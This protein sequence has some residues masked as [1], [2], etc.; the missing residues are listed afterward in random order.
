MKRD[1]N[2]F[3]GEEEF[4]KFLKN[5]IIQY[6][7]L[8]FQNKKG[9][10]SFI[11]NKL[12]DIK[13]PKTANY[14]KITDILKEKSKDFYTDM[15]KVHSPL[16]IAH[17]YS[18]YRMLIDIFWETTWIKTFSP[19]YKFLF[20]EE[21]EIK[22][23]SDQR[24]YA[25]KIITELSQQELQKKWIEY[26]S[27]PFPFLFG[28]TT[29]PVI[30]Y[31]HLT[32]GPLGFL[33]SLHYRE[34]EIFGSY[35]PV[36]S[37][38]VNTTPTGEDI[39]DWEETDAFKV[40]S[41]IL[42]EL[43]RKINEVTSSYPLYANYLKSI[44]FEFPYSEWEKQLLNF[45]KL[46]K[47]QI[48]EDR[49]P[50]MFYQMVQLTAMFFT[51]EEIIDLLNRLLAE[52]KL[53]VKSE[54]E[55]EDLKIMGEG[56]VKRPKSWLA[57][58]AF[59]LASDIASIKSKEFRDL[60]TDVLENGTIKYLEQV[61]DKDFE[62][63]RRI[64]IKKK[65]YKFASL[66]KYRIPK[67]K[68]I[69]LVLESYGLRTPSTLPLDIRGEINSYI[70]EIQKFEE[71]CETME[72]RELIKEII[73]LLRDGRMHFE[74]ILKEWVF[75]IISLI[76]HYE[77]SVARG[78]SSNIFLL[79]WPIFYISYDIERKLNEIKKKYREFLEK[80]TSEFNT[81]GNLRI[82]IDNYIK[83]ERIEFTL[84]DWL[85]LLQLSVRY[86]DE[87]LSNRFWSA[88]PAHF[89]RNTQ[90]SISEIESFLNKEG[91]LKLLN[92]ASHERAMIEFQENIENRQEALNILSKVREEIL[93]ELQRL[94]EL[95]I[96]TKEVTDGQTGLKYY[97]ARLT[98]NKSIKIY[99]TQFVGLNFL[100]YLIP[101]F[102]KEEDIAIYPIIITNLTDNVF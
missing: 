47:N 32:I 89:Y 101:R 78:L 31:E 14:T 2:L 21:P 63:F 13:I 94:P 29:T 8:K 38:L 34:K 26:S 76:L 79:D 24:K 85:S 98:T 58:P 83:K 33:F 93:L 73:D 82:K 49:I 55:I 28:E 87:N 61:F 1:N 90:E 39:F 48:K 9:L 42:K 37:I 60:L 69:R 7:K 86:A 23:K 62:T 19:F 4:Q 70:E 44:G 91:A 71:E 43:N 95:V 100:Y 56:I 30:H 11:E 77:N 15:L 46:F 99:G 18:F 3:Q 68:A 59:E 22:N 81:S 10:I 97:E 75:I 66:E 41:D 6:I 84:G 51:D 27:E 35:E 45:V 25:A 40:F 96:I 88:L 102:E 16:E 53:I 92:L 52:E 57:R 12:L 64:C 54:T 50:P 65:L 20:N 72:E 67:K 5:S 80:L 17:L 74:R 36:L